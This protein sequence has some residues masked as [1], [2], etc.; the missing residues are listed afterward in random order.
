MKGGLEKALRRPR[1]RSAQRWAATGA[2]LLCMPMALQAAGAAVAPGTRLAYGGLMIDGLQRRL[3][4]IRYLMPTDAWGG[5]AFVRHAGAS[6]DG[7]VAGRHAHVRA[8]AVQLGA[9]A[10][11]WNED[12]ASHRVGL[13][14]DRGRLRTRPGGAAQTAVDMKGLSVWYTHQRDGGAYVDAVLGRARPAGG[15]ASAARGSLWAL[16]VEAGAPLPLG[17]KLALEPQVQLT[18][19]TLRVGALRA[20]QAGARLGL[21]LARV[22]NE[23]FV[24]YAQVD[25]EHQLG[26]IDDRNSAVRHGTAVRL[27]AGLTIKAHRVVDIY[28]DAGLQRRLAGG[29]AG[30][31]FQ[32]G[33][34]INF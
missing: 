6:F 26:R 28:A 20:R 8:S 22:D 10:I 27:S 12:G 5:E 25:L 31:T 32:A 19:Q 14:L 2:G 3:G 15:R 4:E 17:E 18:H 34:R 16:S 11:Y 7:G 21:R 9:G 30:G 13:A 24:P 1:S 33:L 23:R 29:S